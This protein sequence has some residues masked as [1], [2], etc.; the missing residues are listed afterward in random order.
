MSP[1]ASTAEENSTAFAIVT[2]LGW[3]SCCVGLGPEG[4]EVG[5][6]R[7]ADDDLDAFVL[8]LTDDARE[9]VAERLE[10]AGIDDRVAGRCGTGREAGLRV[11]ERVAVGVVGAQQTDLL[12]GLTES[13]MLHEDTDELL[14]TPEEVV[15]PVEPGG[16]VAAATE[17]VRLPRRERARGRARRS[18]RTGRRPG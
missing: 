1:S 9:V 4:G 15:R 17:E 2:S 7:D 6:D 12:V 3:K 11:G 14:G 5:R 13:H 10:A 18:P 16:G 8:E